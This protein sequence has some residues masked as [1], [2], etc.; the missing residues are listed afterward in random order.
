MV[1]SDD[2]GESAK[3]TNGGL[4]G[5]SI[6]PLFKDKSSSFSSL[7]PLFLRGVG[8]LGA[9]TVDRDS[10]DSRDPLLEVSDGISLVLG[11]ILEG[12]LED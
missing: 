5:D 7:M 8:Y 11:L 2:S 6:P 4:S 9:E 1:A 10:I 12:I 3:F